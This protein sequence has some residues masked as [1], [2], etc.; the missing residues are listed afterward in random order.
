LGIFCFGILAGSIVP[1]LTRAFFALQDTKTPVVIGIISMALN[2]GL[3][4]LFTFFLGFQ[5]IFRN[6]WIDF[7]KLEEIESVEVIGL[8]LALSLAI[9]F[10]LILLLIFFYKKIG[11][12][13]I[14]EISQSL[15]KILIAGTL[16][17]I[18]TYFIRQDIARWVDMN[19]FLGVFWQTVAASLGG[20]FVYLFA[21]YFLRSSEIGT[22]KFSI[23]EQFRK[24]QDE[25]RTN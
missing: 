17:V 11:D 8:P 9:I 19:T 6:F 14:K 1:L 23:L 20:I 3:C 22:I 24:P 4:F 2:I 7:L 10:Q 16:M 18:T 13:K 25:P 12:F 21:A 15:G 5:N